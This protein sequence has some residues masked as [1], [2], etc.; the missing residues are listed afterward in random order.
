MIV[1]ATVL[2]LLAT[3]PAALGAQPAKLDEDFAGFTWLVRS[4]TPAFQRVLSGIVELSTELLA[5][6]A[7]W[8][9][10]SGSAPGLARAALPVW[11]CIQVLVIMVAMAWDL[12][13]RERLARV[14]VTPHSL[15]LGGRVQVPLTEIV[16]V[17]ARGHGIGPLHRAELVLRTEART[18][19]IAADGDDLPSLGRLAARIAALV[20]ASRDRAHAG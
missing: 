11:A 5:L 15:R 2:R 10:W 19:V 20:P 6:V 3:D 13:G 12:G 17:T 1:L 16:E 18:R 9:W 4:R 8:A 7:L 14:R